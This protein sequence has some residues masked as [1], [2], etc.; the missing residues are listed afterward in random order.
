M[1]IKEQII[2]TGNYVGFMLSYANKIGINNLILY[3]H[4]GKLV[5][6]ASGIF[7]TKHSVADGRRE[8]IATHAGLCGADKETIESVFKSKNTEEMIEILKKKD[9]DKDVLNSISL[10]IRK[11]CLERFNL[12]VKV[13][14]VD[15]QG[16]QL[17]SM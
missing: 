6:L 13:I 14:L 1:P 15:M 16:N 9:I 11:I 8:V 4:I 17:N 5:K 3:G 7:N 12:N 10:T 2:Q